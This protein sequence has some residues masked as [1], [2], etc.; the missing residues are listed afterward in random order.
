[1]RMPVF[2]HQKDPLPRRNVTMRARLRNRSG[3]FDASTVRRMP[4]ASYLALWRSRRDFNEM[5][6]WVRASLVPKV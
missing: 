2:L 6:R 4:S 3:F 5:S 1:M